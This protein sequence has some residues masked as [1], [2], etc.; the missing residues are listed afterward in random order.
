M[1]KRNSVKTTAKCLL[2]VILILAAAFCLLSCGNRTAR[3]EINEPAGTFVVVDSAGNEIPYDTLLLNG[4]EVIDYQCTSVM[5][6]ESV[7]LATEKGDIVRDGNT[8]TYNGKGYTEAAV[9][10]YSLKNGVLNIKEK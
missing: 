7:M 4:K 6:R 5:G 10:T 9:F 3:L 2:T 8:T 1:R